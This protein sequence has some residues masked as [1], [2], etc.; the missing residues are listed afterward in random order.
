MLWNDTDKTAYFHFDFNSVN[1]QHCLRFG[2]NL[3]TLD[4][5]VLLCNYVQN[6][7]RI[8]ETN[9]IIS[10][11]QWDVPLQWPSSEFNDELSGKLLADFSMFVNVS[12]LIE[13][14]PVYLTIKL[15]FDSFNWCPDCTIHSLNS[16]ASDSLS[17]SHIY[18]EPFTLDIQIVVPSLLLNSEI[19]L[20]FSIDVEDSCECWSDDYKHFNS[21]LNISVSCPYLIESPALLV[22]PSS[23]KWNNGYLIEY[24]HMDFGDSSLGV[25]NYSYDLISESI[26]LIL[27]IILS[28]LSLNFLMQLSTKGMMLLFQPIIVLRVQYFHFF[29]CFLFKFA[30]SLLTSI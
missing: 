19:Q 13:Q 4:I 12:G 5:S 7:P 15:W 29:R 25:F 11:F 10:D 26:F 24:N 30:F 27:L 1:L 6:E 3:L 18:V 28:E 16:S 14:V 2:P 17:F 22:P 8:N 21:K 20:S 9:V 23:P